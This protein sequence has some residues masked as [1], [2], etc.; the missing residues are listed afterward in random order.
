MA[1]SSNEGGWPRA[2]WSD[3]ANSLLGSWGSWESKGAWKVKCDA[4][5]RVKEDEG[6]DPEQL[7]GWWKKASALPTEFFG[8]WKP[9]SVRGE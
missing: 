9:D 6:D 7:R 1:S 2:A 3:G 5:E 4:T 8:T